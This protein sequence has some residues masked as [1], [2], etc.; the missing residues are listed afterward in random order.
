MSVREIHKNI[1]S[2][3]IY[4]GL[5]EARD[6]DD[7]IS[8][9]ALS[10]LFPPQLEKCHQDTRLCVVANIAYMK[11]VYIHN[12]HLDCNCYFKKLKYLSQNSY[13]RRSGGK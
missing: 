5:K 10:S 12:N 8:V 13:N 1:V 4:G 6:E 2:A 11:K 9:S 7:N 3:T